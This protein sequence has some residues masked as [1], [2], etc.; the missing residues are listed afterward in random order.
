MSNEILKSLI[1]NILRV[2]LTRS[3]IKSPYFSRME[4]N[5]KKPLPGS[6]KLFTID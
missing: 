2:F 4:L 5:G 1:Q 3:S 6:M